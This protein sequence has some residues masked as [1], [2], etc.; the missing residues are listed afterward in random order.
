MQPSIY[1]ST[2]DL[3]HLKQQA[4]KLKREQQIPHTQALETIAKAVGFHHWH[5][6]TQSHANSLPTER[7]FLSGC[8][9]IFEAKE[10]MDVNTCDGVFINDSFLELLMRDSLYAEFGKLIDEDD[11]EQRSFS[12]TLSQSEFNEDAYDFLNSFMFFRINEQSS[13][14]TVDEVI[15][16]ISKSVFWMPDYIRLRGELIDTYELPR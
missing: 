8:I 7:A 3:Q 15:A 10:G 5:H 9:L 16:L 6:V 4:R 12:E 2:R 14:E 13:P 1:V 11:P